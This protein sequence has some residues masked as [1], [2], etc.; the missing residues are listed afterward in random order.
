MWVTNFNLNGQTYDPSAIPGIPPDYARYFGPGTGGMITHNS[1]P[2][3]P[4]CVELANANPRVVYGAGKPVP[5]CSA[6]N[7]G[8]STRR[9]GGVALG[10][11]E[12]RVRDLLGAPDEV[13]RGFLRYCLKD[14]ATYLVGQPGDRSGDAGGA[15][16]G[17]E[18]S[19]LLYTDSLAYRYRR[20][21]PGL[22]T[23]ALRR[24]WRHAV[25]RL[26]MG[27]VAVYAPSRTSPVIV[28]LRA[29]HVRWI[30]VY[31]RRRIRSS[32]ALRDYLLRTTPD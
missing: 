12:R 4:H 31:D 19:A 16:A 11:P 8:V 10:D 7:G 3:D 28:G 13:R 6:A 1:V 30:A 21:R 15:G 25:F 9:L 26:R 5:R 29:K 2:T 23:S 27:R 17:D 20:V 22:G 32:A 24:R 14:G 18:P